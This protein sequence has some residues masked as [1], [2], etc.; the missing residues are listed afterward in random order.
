MSRKLIITEKPSAA[1]DYARVLKVPSNAGRNYMENDQ[2]VITW[3]YGHLV[4]LVYPEVYDEKYKKWRL[5]DLPFWPE[6]YKYGV[7]QSS[8]QQ[9]ETIH[10]FLHDEEI[11]TVYWAG[12]SGKE[13]QTIEEN[14]RMLGGVREGMVELRVWLDSLTDEEIF[15]GLKEARPMSEYDNLAKSGIMRTIEDYSIGI[16]FSRALSVKYGRM[17]NDAA[18]TTRYSA[19]AIGRVMTCVLGMV[20]QREREIRNFVETPFYRVLGNFDDA[21]FDAEWKTIEGSA[22]FESPLL[23]KENGFNEE[24]DALVLIETLENKEAKI[25]KR[26][27]STSKKRAPLLFNLTELQLECSKRFKINPAKTLEIAQSLYEKKFTTY[28]RTDARVLSTA[29]AKEIY[30]NLNRLKSYEPTGECV[31]KIINQKMYIDIIKPPFTDDSKVTDHYAIIPTGQTSGLEKLSSVER[32]VYDLIVRRFLSIF[33]PPAEYTNVKLE[34]EIE[35]EHFFA[36]TKILEKPGYMEIAGIANEKKKEDDGEKFS[37]EKFLAFVKDAAVGDLVKVNGF[38]IKEGKTSPPKRYTG[39]TLA[40]A[41]EHAGNLIEDEKLREQIKNSGIGTSATR[42]GIIQK[43]IDIKYLHEHPKTQII[44]PEKIGEMIYEV[45]A[46][47]IPSLLSPK[48]TASWEK[49]LEGIVNGSVDYEEYRDKLKAFI[50]NETNKMIGAD[51]TN[52]LAVRFHPFTGKE[53]KGIATRKPLGVKCPVCGGELTTTAFGYG[54]SNYFDEKTKCRFSIGQIAG[55]SLEEEDFID[56]INNGRTGIIDGFVSK[57]KSKFKA[58]LKLVKD[59]DGKVQVQFDFSEN[60]I[61]YV[62][63]LKCPICNGRLVKTGYGVSCEQRMG[64]HKQCTFSVGEIAGRKL[65]TD[66][67]KSL[68]MDGKTQIL[69]GFK[70][71]S[72][73]NFKARLVLK[74]D[75]EN[76]KTIVFDFDGIEPDKLEGVCCPDCGGEI[77]IRN[78]GFGCANFSST[79]PNSCKFY[80]GKI[81]NK[82][83]PQARV[84]ELLKEG[85]TKTIRGFKSKAGKNF[86]ACLELK[87]NEEGKS[88]IVFDFEHVEAK[89]LKDVQCPICGGDIVKTSFGYGCSNY[90]R[91][92]EAESCRFNI[93]KIAGVKIKDAQII[94]LLREGITDVICGFKSKKGIE[95]KARLCLGKDEH[96]KVNGIK[97]VFEDLD[98]HLEGVK[99]PKCGGEIIKNDWGYKCLNNIKEREDACDFFVGKVAG[100]ELSKE[101]FVKLIMEK[102]TDVLKGFTSKTGSLFDARLIFD[103]NY[104]VVFDFDNNNTANEPAKEEKDGT[105]QN[106]ESL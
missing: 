18:A 22:Y 96:G 87:K 83:I 105:V 41:M 74:D 25:K 63:D 24:K 62:E 65:T 54:C 4:E 26:E 61:E 68:L 57:N 92:N 104:H 94:Q 98:E 9:Y 35:Q 102:R 13:G 76:K 28:P 71:K 14:I 97:F 49:G 47:T 90:N 69:S 79:D 7:I 43:L 8:A 51:Y 32:S 78:S 103:E 70:S 89:V 84:L 77:L 67:L 3:C 10:R 2:Y 66:E 40:S 21:S 42:A 34:I 44:T 82:V 31:E 48:M 100:L 29:I 60:P 30:K 1:R 86:D 50:I 64:E 27:I 36:S 38:R 55:V 5:E 20:V 99:C 93:G 11:D 6:S 81:A 23:Y 19:I 37:P 53:A 17:L 75:E 15:K 56:L 85:R 45:V 73:K 95:F 39:G 80:I 33:Y 72:K 91:E 106:K 16:N 59:E 12:D 88:E 101:Q 58:V 52:Q 46:L